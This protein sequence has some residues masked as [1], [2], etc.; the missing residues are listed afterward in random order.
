[1][2]KHSIQTDLSKTEEQVMASRDCIG[3]DATELIGNTPMVYLRKI[4]R[5]FPGTIAAKVEYLNPACS[6]KDRIGLAMV[7]AAEDAGQVSYLYL[8]F[9]S[10]HIC[11]L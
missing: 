11:L 4:G 7:Q 2:R 8:F 9:S 5:G 3:E 6:V 10:C 1:M